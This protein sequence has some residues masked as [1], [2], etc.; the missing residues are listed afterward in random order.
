[1][2]EKAPNDILLLSG[3]LN[4]VTLRDNG[5]KAFA[6]MN[7]KDGIG[8]TDGKPQ[9]KSISLQVVG[10]T[11]NFLNN[12]YQTNKLLKSKGRKTNNL[13]QISSGMLS[14]YSVKKN[15]EKEN[16]TFLKVF[17]ANLLDQKRTILDSTEKDLISTKTQNDKIITTG[18]LNY[19]QENN[20]K[21]SALAYM[22]IIDGKKEDG[23]NNYVSIS[24]QVFGEAKD[25]LSLVY[26]DILKE[27]S[28]N[29]TK[30]V[31][32]QITSGLI[33][34][35]QNSEDKTKTCLKCFKAQEINLQNGKRYIVNDNNIDNSQT[36]VINE[37]IIVE[38]FDWDDD[39][40]F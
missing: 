10:D 30:K 8:Q 33:T 28:R 34:S 9:Y 13:I 22:S 20:K 23:S 4:Y 6:Y 40:P 18:I 26:E 2:N 16:F 37:P 3:F 7:V 24:M 29:N 32:I 35:Y 12:I 21:T 19:F 39:V 27:K 25:K 14:S 5:K 31:L 36:N 15:N 17:K 11:V 38:S 1:M